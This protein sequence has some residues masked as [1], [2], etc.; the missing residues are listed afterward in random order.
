LENLTLLTK[1]IQFLRRKIQNCMFKDSIG[2]FLHVV[3]V[4]VGGCGLD[5]HFVLQRD[6]V[7]LLLDS[8]GFT[9]LLF[10]SFTNNLDRKR[11]III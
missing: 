4:E 7:F 9:E 5:L 6:P 2:I 8:F 11:S 10:S 1:I 3:V